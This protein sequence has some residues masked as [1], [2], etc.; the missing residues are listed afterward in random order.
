MPEEVPDAFTSNRLGD[1]RESDVYAR[2]FIGSSSLLTMTPNHGT[3]ICSHV[4][5]PHHIGR[6]G[7]GLS[8]LFAELS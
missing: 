4:L 1:H 6:L 5:S 8:L 7:F 2:T 3:I